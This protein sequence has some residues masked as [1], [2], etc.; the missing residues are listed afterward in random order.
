V[1]SAVWPIDRGGHE[2]DAPPWSR[3]E[4]TLMS[5][6]RDVRRAYDKALSGL[7]LNLAEAAVLAHLGHAP[8]LTQAELARRVGKSRARL[9]VHVDSLEAKGAVRRQADPKDRR[10]W[11]ITLTPEGKQLWE[12]SVDIDRGIRVRL[13]AGTTNAER[14][15]LDSMLSRIHANIAELLNGDSD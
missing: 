11:L 3:V 6:A 15:Q 4:G 14:A 5:T 7:G 10:V 9:G 8:Q 13:R 1:S 12:R 2:L